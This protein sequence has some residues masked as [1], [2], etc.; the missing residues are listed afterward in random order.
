MTYELFKEALIT[1]LSNHFPPDA[2][3]AIHRLPRNNQACLEGLTIME[4]GSN[5]AP[6]IHLAEHYSH[7]SEGRS[8]LQVFQDIL[9]VYE[10]LRP[11]AE[12]NVTLLES[13][14]SQKSRI[15]YK[16]VHYERNRQL[17]A[18][19]PHI[20]YLDLA[21]IFY[22]LLNTDPSGS[23]T[24][25]IQN[26]HLKRWELSPEQLYELAQ[27]NTPILLPPRIDNLMS[28]LQDI[29][30]EHM[31]ELPM[32]DP[33]GE[34]SPLYLLTNQSG[35]QGAACILYPGILQGFARQKGHD[36]YI[37]PSSIH[38]TLLLPVSASLTADELN[39]M[40]RDTNRTQ[41]APEEILSD[42]AYYYS[43]EENKVTF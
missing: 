42:H 11:Q 14:A 8:F 7:L 23:A 17:L 36:L 26:S 40:I 24:V 13:R 25:L 5:V 31:L 29:P 34:G 21:I 4:A 22:S 37:I 15:A 32:D 12:L 16:L 35:L 10:R 41:L 30:G 20:P 43:L 2:Q 1:E 28:L 3:I 19:V 33:D 18:T 9:D 39:E 6:A 27:E 38:E